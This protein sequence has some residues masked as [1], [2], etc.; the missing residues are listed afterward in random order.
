MTDENS[1]TQMGGR[2]L[3]EEQQ[4]IL[5][6]IAKFGK[7]R[8]KARAVAL[9]ALDEGVTRSEACER[10]G[11]SLGQI[12]YLLATFHQKGME[13]FTGYSFGGPEPQAMEEEPEE[14]PIVKKEE[15]EEKEPEEQ[16]IVKKEEPEEKEKA[17]KKDKKDKSKGKKKKGDKKEKKP[18]KKKKGKKKDKKAK[19]KKGKKGKG[20]KKKGKK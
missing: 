17:K 15:P 20:G 6:N 18:K 1:T 7:D 4:V 12:K 5:Q 3:D 19:G 16:P 13:L 14:Q 8:T 11:L 2:L 9:L 10:S